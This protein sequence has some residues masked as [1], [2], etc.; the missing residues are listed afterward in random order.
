MRNVMLFWC[1]MMM[2]Y[3]C[4]ELSTTQEQV[5][6]LRHQ[7][8]RSAFQIETLRRRLAN[9][10]EDTLRLDRERAEQWRHIRALER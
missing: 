8:E 9:L 7:R 4:S 1:F 2:T 10:E 6:V 5:R 3:Q